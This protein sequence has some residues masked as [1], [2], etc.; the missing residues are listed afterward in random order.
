MNH[1]IRRASLLDLDLLLPLFGAYREFYGKA[2]DGAAEREYLSE[3]MSREQCVVFLAL[4]G[5]K[6][7]GFTLL[8]P[9][10]ASVG[11]RARWTL[12]DLYVDPACR[13]R[14][15]ARRLLMH[16]AEFA[17]ST[18]AADVQLLTAKDN[19]PAR[20]LYEALGWKE[21]EAFVRYVM[22]L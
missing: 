1:T 20:G 14:G 13:G 3:R 8:Y 7:V 18:G 6:A 12:N 22:K 10:F 17:R 4:E 2:R 21:D 19:A 11:M 9:T 15:A 16:A 5:A